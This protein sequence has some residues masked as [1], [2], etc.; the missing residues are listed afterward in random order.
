M[1]NPMGKVALFLKMVI[2]MWVNISKESA[3]AM[4]SIRSQMENVMKANGFKISSM[5]AEPIISQTTTSMWAC[6]FVTTSKV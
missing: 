3:K 6:G 5:G 4:A 1:V 2:L